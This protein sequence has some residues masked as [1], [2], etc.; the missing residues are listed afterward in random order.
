MM[1]ACDLQL[2]HAEPIPEKGK[3][4]VLCTHGTQAQHASVLDCCCCNAAAA[5]ALSTWQQSLGVQPLRERKEAF[6]PA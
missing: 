2:V 4:S 5:A 3:H 1:Q 6:V